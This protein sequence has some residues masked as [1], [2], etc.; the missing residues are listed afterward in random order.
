VASCGA[1]LLLARPVPHTAA[2]AAAAAAAAPLIAPQDGQRSTP[3]NEA[4]R[5]MGIGGLMRQA[6]KLVRGC[7][8]KQTEEEFTMDITS[9]IGWFKARRLYR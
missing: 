9:V 5:V 1:R 6:I 4:L 7:D 3:M 8:I 2:A